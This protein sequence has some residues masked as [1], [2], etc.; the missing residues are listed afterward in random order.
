MQEREKNFNV[1]HSFFKKYEDF[2]ILPR[3]LQNAKP[4]WFAY[5]L[6]IKEEAPFERIE[7][8][9]Y[10]E[11]NMVQTRLLFSGNLLR[12]PAYENLKP[13]I[14]GTLANS[15]IVTERTFFLGVYPGLDKEKIAYMHEI[16]TK[17]FEE[18]SKK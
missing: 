6:T 2:F 10:L 11:Q 16:L 8:I 9:K 1:M 18:K 3:S 17:F 7:L 15:D 14:S 4:C 5:P 12:H 13:K